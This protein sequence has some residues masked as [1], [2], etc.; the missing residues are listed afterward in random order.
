MNV[1]IDCITLPE[2]FSGAANYIINLTKS[3]LKAERSFNIQ[4]YCQKQHGSL[5]EKYMRTGDQLILIKISNRIHK[6]LYYEKFL[7]KKLL[8]HNTDIFLATHYITPPQNPKYK[9]I[10]IFHDMGFI[11]HK[12]YYPFI[13]HKYFQLMIPKFIKRSEKIITVSQSTLKDLNNAMPQS[14]PKAIYIYPGTDHLHGI[15]SKPKKE[16]AGDIPYILA[17]NS[18][19]KRKNIPF[20]I[21]VFNILKK[22]YNIIHNLIIVGRM[23][24]GYSDL[25]HKHKTSPYS[26]NIFLKQDIQ[27]NELKDLYQRADLFLNA[28]VY[29]GFGFTP[30]EAISQNCPAFLFPNNVC[31]ELFRNHTYLIDSINPHIWAEKIYSE[32]RNNYPEKISYDSLSG[33]SWQKCAF[34]FI[35]LFNSITG[36]SHAQRRHSDYNQPH[37][38]FRQCS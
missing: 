27:G 34:N 18:F 26:R 29:E 2:N 37:P 24:N 21:D 9:I 1:G 15:A 32:M 23:N 22:D 12:E 10:T 5:F 11:L 35:S 6:L 8:R 13:K 3:L 31:K 4:V 33:L 28:S 14:R 20:L 25:K 17:V 38:E 7:S 30:P 19:E 36:T 16:Q